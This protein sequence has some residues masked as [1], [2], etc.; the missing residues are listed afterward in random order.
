MFDSLLDGG[1]GYPPPLTDEQI[2]QL[3]A[4]DPE[5]PDPA[6]VAASQRVR[7]AEL[8]AAGQSAPMS[9][10][11]AGQLA[12]LDPAALTDDQQVALTVGLQRAVNTAHAQRADAVAGFARAARP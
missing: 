3:I 5:P 9:A 7:V 6:D 12:A 2:E 1:G 8:L 10:V 4:G 11:L